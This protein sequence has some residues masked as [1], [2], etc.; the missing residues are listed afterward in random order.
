MFSADY[1]SSILKHQRKV[2]E[3]QK[4]RSQKGDLEIFNPSVET[5]FPSLYDNMSMNIKASSCSLAVFFIESE[6]LI[7]SCYMIMYLW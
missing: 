2:S 3:K 1:E 6:S 4:W 5:T 7:V